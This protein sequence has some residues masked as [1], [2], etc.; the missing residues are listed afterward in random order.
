[1]LEGELRRITSENV[2]DVICCPGG[3]EVEHT[4]FSCDISPV[5]KWRRELL[6]HGM[7]G[8]VLY[9]EGKPTGFIE[10]MPVEKAPYPIEGENLAVIMCFHWASRGQDDEHQTVEKEL[11]EAAIDK[12][13][14]DFE[15]AAAIA[16]DHPVHFTIKMFEDVGFSEVDSQDYISLMWM[17][18]DPK[19]KKPELLGPN[20]EPEDLLEK[21]RLT[22]E[23]GYSNRCPYSIND[24]EKVKKAVSEL[25]DDRI[26]FRAHRIDTKK[27]AV[28]FSKRGWDW[29]W[30]FLNGEEIEHM[31]KSKEELKHLIV[32]ELEELD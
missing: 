2:S 30:L 23:L 5:L 27:E 20:F 24:H 6:K 11:L 8:I 12:M 22:V 18:F 26:V 4:D 10:Y 15:G 16:W 29:N 13:K 3:L 7:E 21:G 17:P 14:S 31:R 1:M 28:K 19:G 9:Q 32:K 25:D